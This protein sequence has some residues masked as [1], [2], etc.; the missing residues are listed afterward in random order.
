MRTPRFR[1]YTKNISY[2]R[3]VE[4][5]LDL[6]DTDAITK[7]EKIIANYTKARHAVLT[8][9][10]RMAIYEGLRALGKTGEIILSPITGSEVISLVILAGFRPVFCDVAHGTWNMDSSLIEA[11]ITEKTVAIMTTHFYGN[12]NTNSAVRALCDKHKLFMIEDAAQAIG[13]WQDGKHAGTIGDFGILSFSHSKNVTSFYGGC[14]ITNN[15]EIAD[16]VRAAIAKYPPVKKSWL[17]KKVIGCAIMDK[18]TFAPVFQ[19]LSPLIKFAYK[20]NIRWIMGL[21]MQNLNTVITKMPTHYL[22][23][24]SPAQAKAVADKWPEIN[25]DTAHR[26]QCVE[27]YYNQLKDLVSIACTK[28]PGDRSHTFLYYPVQVADKHVLQRYLIENNCDVAIQHAV[29]CADL[30]QYKKYFRDCPVARAAYE[31]TLMLPT[32]RGFPLA[33]SERYAKTIR[34]YFN[35]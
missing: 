26:M 1:L 3:M 4:G 14:L 29:N 27:I 7:T 20:H 12:M 8:S 19:F 23:R 24:I 22:T 35:A 25:E 30:P 28:P 33:Q 5:A 6:H 18:S 31:G 13:A 11:R 16:R 10:G 17:Y 32:Y 15:S 2:L 21:A 9:K 34:E